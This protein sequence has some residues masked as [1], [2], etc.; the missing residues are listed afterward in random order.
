MELSLIMSAAKPPE[1]VYWLTIPPNVIKI[2]KQMRTKM[3]SEGLEELAASIKE[4]GQI[5][6]GIVVGL[7]ESEAGKYLKLINEMWGM[8]YQLTSFEP[9]FLKE[10]QDNFYLFLVAGHRRFEAVNLAKLDSFYC[11]LRLETKFSRALIL[12]FMENLHEAV[13]PDDEARFLTFLW[14]EE[15][16]MEPGLSLAKFA[17]KL[18]KK[19]ESVRRS[20]RFTSLPV[21]VQKLVLPSQEFK[22]GVAFGILCE[23][24]RLQEARQEKNKAYEEQEL[25]HLA[26]VLVVQQK[27]AKAVALWVSEQIK[28]LNGQGGLFDLSIETVLDGARHSVSSGLEHLVRIGTEHVRAVT[29]FH[30]AGIV[31][32]VASGSAVNA[33]INAIRLTSDLAP[34]IL[35]GIRGGRHAP[36]AR[37]TI[38]TLEPE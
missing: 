16:S 36:V 23:L 26:Y 6:P 8:D 4:V 29:R 17:R 12:Q 9:V 24:A 32:K 25:L 21:T 14:R 3:S 35:E 5:N 34:Q 33:V 38:A 2:L 18:G 11:Q 30:R 1:G 27:T 37:K 31:R 10:L 20:I 22:R 19:P 28:E 7:I 15:K 13:P